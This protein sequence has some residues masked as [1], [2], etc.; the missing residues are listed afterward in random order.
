MF[1]DHYEQHGSHLPD[2]QLLHC[3]L[4]RKEEVQQ[5]EAFRRHRRRVEN[6][7]YPLLSIYGCFMSL[8]KC[9]GVCLTQSLHTPSIFLCMLTPPPSPPLLH[10]V[11]GPDP[12]TPLLLYFEP[13]PQ[14]QSLLLLRGKK[15]VLIFGLKYWSGQRP[16]ISITSKVSQDS[17]LAV[18]DEMNP[19]CHFFSANF[20]ESEKA[21]EPLFC[22]FY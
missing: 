11:V 15:K 6:H 21:C 7:F 4:W 10:L 20:P 9:T 18:T 8:W 13:L 19:F 17:P 3:P 16:F 12:L 1:W 14:L 5:S 2:C 22:M